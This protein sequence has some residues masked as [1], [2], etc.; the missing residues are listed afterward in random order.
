MVQIWNPTR[1]APPARKQ[2]AQM[3]TSTTPLA[4]GWKFRKAHPAATP[5]VLDNLHD[6]KSVPGEIH[7]D[8]LAHDLIPDPFKKKNELLVQW[9]GEEA[10]H[11][12]L[13][14]PSPSGAGKH[15]LVFEGLDTFAIVTLN[16]KEIL[17][18]SNMFTP[19][20]VD[21]TEVLKKNEGENLLE[22]VFESAYL[23]GKR[24]REKYPNFPW[25]G[26]NG[27]TSRFAVRKAQYHYV[28]SHVL[29]EC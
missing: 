20:R 9:V 25:G 13:S 26:W 14:F 3:A 2:P 23:R 5:H 6:V 18:T 7:V 19:Y 28:S 21:V 24:E 8:L 15:E 1:A 27:D 10:W 4:S 29:R 16:G 12:E 22:V 17:Q 11:Y